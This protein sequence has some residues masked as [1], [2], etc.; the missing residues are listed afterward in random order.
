M[1]YMYIYIYLSGL[2]TVYSVLA[3]QE[4]VEEDTEVRHHR[5]L[6]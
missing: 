5:V 6:W 3:S 2:R 4:G 1:R